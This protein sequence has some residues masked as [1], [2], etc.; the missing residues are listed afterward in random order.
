MASA[1]LRALESG[2][3]PQERERSQRALD[4][5]S[6]AY[7]TSEKT[8]NRIINLAKDGVVAE[9]KADEAELAYR[10]AKAN[11]EAAKAGHSLV[12][13]GAR[14]EEI[15]AAREQV[16]ELTA[17][18]KAAQSNLKLAEA[19]AKMISVREADVRMAQQQIAAS[20]GALNEVNAYLNETRIVSPIDGSVAAVISRRGEMAAPG[21][22]IFTIART[23]AYWVDV[24]MD[25]SQWAHRKIGDIVT[26]EIPS[27]GGSVPGKILQLLPA[28]DFATKRATNELGSFDIR[29]VQLRVQLDGEVRN[30][31]RGL[32]ARVRLDEKGADSK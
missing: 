25:E 4:A 19:G 22:A 11:Y 15:Q 10:S 30:L 21:Y 24:Y 6:A 1:K 28:A 9:Q 23:D 27:M 3:R 17:R 26:V 7:E 31:A 5:A 8:Y 18:L 32:T 2:A 13:E 29:S 14:L 20:R 12:L 16:Q